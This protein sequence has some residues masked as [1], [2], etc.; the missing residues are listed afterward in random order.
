MARKGRQAPKGGLALKSRSWG[1]GQLLSSQ[2]EVDT[3]VKQTGPWTLQRQ[4]QD[5]MF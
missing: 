4:R 2:R 3:D 5:T 1:N